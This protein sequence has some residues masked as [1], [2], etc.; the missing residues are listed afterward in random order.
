M[1]I[2]IKFI[3]FIFA[4]QILSCSNFQNK[5]QKTIDENNWLEHAVSYQEAGFNLKFKY[6]NNIIVADNIDNCICLGIKTEFYDEKQTSFED[7]TRQWCICVQ[8][9]LEYSIDY[10]ISSWK[11][12]YT[13]GISEQKDSIVIDNLKAIRITFKNDTFGTPYRQLI[14]IKKYSALFE[15]MNTN[16]ATEKDFETFCKSIKIQE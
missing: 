8:D 7:N 2:Y 9:T 4:L 15:I 6:P 13:E 3:F 1:M 12:H 16:V 5:P 10:L 11:S 14:Y